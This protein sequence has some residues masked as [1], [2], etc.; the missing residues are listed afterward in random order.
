MTII[1]FDSDFIISQLYQVLFSLRTEIGIFCAAFIAHA[2]LFGKY[3]PSFR[4]GKSDKSKSKSVGDTPS[5]NAQPASGSNKVFAMAPEDI[6]RMKPETLASVLRSRLK[7]VPA[8]EVEPPLVGLLQNAGRSPPAKLLAAISEVAK[9]RS[10]PMNSMLGEYLIR[11]YYVG[12]FDTEFNELLAVIEAEVARKGQ[13]LSNGI[14]VQALKGDLR[15]TDFQAALQRL[16]SLRAM[17]EGPENSPSAAPKALVQWLTRL[18]LQKDSFQTLVKKL[19]EL[20]LFAEVFEQILGECA[21]HGDASVL[22]ELEAIGRQDGLQLTDRTYCFLLKGSTEVENAMRL[23]AEGV[24]KVGASKELIVAAA[25]AAFAHDS[26]VFADAILKQLPAVPPAEAVGKL[27]SLT[28]RDAG[29]AKVLD[30]YEKH[31]SGVD[32][33][34]DVATEKGIAQAC[35]RSGKLE[36]LKKML[37]T[38]TDCTKRVGLIK[39]LGADGR[40]DDAFTV[41]RMYPERGACL[42]NAIMDACIDGNRPEAVQEVMGEATQTG[43]ADIVTYNTIIKAHLLV[44]KTREARKAVELM[45]A[46]GLQPNCVTFN[47]MLDAAI[48]SSIDEAWPLIDEMKACGVKPNHITCSILLK[49][50]RAESTPVQVERILD[51]LDTMA[52]DMDEVLLSSVVEACIRVGR[53]DLLVP[54]LKRQGSSRRINVR[55]PHTYGSI[56]RAYGYVKDI[57]SAWETWREMRARHIVPTA[58]TLGC[59]VEAVV[60]NGDPEVGYELIQDMLKDDQCKPLVNAIIY[61]SVL[62][63]FSQQKKFERV[64]AVYQEMLLQKVQFSIVTFNTMVDACSRSGEMSRIPALLKS[65]VSQGIEPNLITYSA[66]LKGYCQENRLDE[67]FELVEGM[68]Q[69]TKFKPDE[70]MFNTLLDGCARQGLYE[71]GMSVLTDMEAAK[72]KPTNFT[73]SV[74]VKLCSRAKRLDRAFEICE[75]ISMK[76]RFRLNVHVYSNLIQACIH[77]KDMKRAFEVFERSLHERV[78]PDVRTYSLLLRGFVSLGEATEAAGLMRAAVGLRGVHPRLMGYAAN[79]LQPQGGL[80]SSL[81]AE[82]IE[83]MS[84]APCREERLAVALLKDIQGKTNVRLDPKLQMRLTTQAVGHTRRSAPKSYA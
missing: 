39:N 14:G 36:V 60:T 38:T 1:N 76:H 80:P 79:A 78:R 28:S 23:F 61:C 83:G 9:E 51:V 31:F 3:R 47:E 18:A 10:L 6:A 19:K 77:H 2:F 26:P 65:M 48:R 49:T 43:V 74:L 63:G 12:H 24:A 41:F 67:A 45:R 53:V 20:G 69:T 22:R 44:G 34:G 82:I 72:I 42:Y 46:A 66:I 57:S 62:K 21:Q 7:E 17:W 71:R 27:L 30:L 64:W 37:M 81:I 68:L 52:D 84:G 13:T 25:N 70:I 29:D 8:S 5:P 11:G 50:I 54:H 40:L 75:E 55:G 58:V 32:L 56:I 16:E 59:M 73:L 4:K 33:S 15:K 35:I